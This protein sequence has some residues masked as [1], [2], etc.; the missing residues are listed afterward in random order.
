MLYHQLFHLIRKYSHFDF[1]SITPNGLAGSLDE[2]FRFKPVN[3]MY[4]TKYFGN[5]GFTLHRN[6]VII[7]LNS[8]V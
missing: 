2:V 1:V 6:R 7:I 5:Q 4:I 8:T 3:T